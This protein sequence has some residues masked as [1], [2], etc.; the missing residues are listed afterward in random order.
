[1]TKACVD[2]STLEKGKI[3]S[4]VLEKGSEEFILC[5][6]TGPSNYDSSIDISFAEG[7][8]ICFR[9]EVS[10]SC[11][12]SSVGRVRHLTIPAF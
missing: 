12:H 6:L 5:N 10:K 9:T 3:A 4:V 11:L 7:E 8:K 2:T 1:M